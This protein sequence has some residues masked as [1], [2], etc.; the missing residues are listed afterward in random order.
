LGTSR[1]GFLSLGANPVDP[2]AGFNMTV[3]S[4]RMAKFCNAVSKKHG[5][6]ARN[7]WAPLWPD[8]NEADVPIT[9]ITN[10]VHLRTWLDPI[11]L[12]PMLDKFLGPNWTREQDQAKT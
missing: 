5:E 6:V 11:W 8:K 1:E 4:L 12:Q 2:N 7:M 9:A 3:F 10:G